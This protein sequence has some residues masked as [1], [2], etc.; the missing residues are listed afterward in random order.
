MSRQ[1]CT[2]RPT[3]RVMI[4]GWTRNTPTPMP[5]ARPASSA[6]SERERDS[7]DR[8]HLGHQRGHDEGHAHRRDEADRQVDAAGEHRQR[9]CRCEDGERDRELEGVPDPT[10]VD[11]ARTDQLEG[12]HEQQEQQDQGDERV[13]SHERGTRP[14]DADRGAGASIGWAAPLMPADLAWP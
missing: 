9:L 12:D 7:E 13:V 2:T 8:V 3:A 14:P 6:G 4:S 10:L 1:P 5:V 11:D